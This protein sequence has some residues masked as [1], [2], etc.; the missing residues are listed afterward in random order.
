MELREMCRSSGALRAAFGPLCTVSEPLR[1]AGGR[2]R[3]PA[4]EDDLAAGGGRRGKLT[5][6]ISNLITR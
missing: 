5:Q 4:G 6:P 1:R 2:R 3:L